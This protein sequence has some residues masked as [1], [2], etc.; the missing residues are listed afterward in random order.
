MRRRARTAS[1]TSGVAALAIGAMTLTSPAEAAPPTPKAAASAPEPGADHWQLSRWHINYDDPESSV[2]TAA[3]RDKNPLEFGYHLQDLLAEGQKAEEKHDDKTALKFWRAVA[4]GVPESNVGF[5]KACRT[6][7]RLGSREKAIE[8][9]AKGLT[10]PPE[11]SPL[12]VTHYA[13]LVLAKD[14]ALDQREIL[15]LDEVSNHLR[16]SKKP[17]ATFYAEQIQCDLAVRLGDEPRWVKCTTALGKL[18]PKDPRTI[19]YQWSLAMKRTDFKAAAG[20][21]AQ[22][23]QSAMKPES[24]A[25]LERALGAARSE[26]RNRWIQIGLG[27]LALALALAFAISRSIRWVRRPRRK[28]FAEPRELPQA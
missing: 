12:E 20:F 22:A 13:S 6:Y 11:Y 28:E 26:Q 21:I 15:D 2:P 5:F 18:A 4:K 14:T 24:L 7:E 16:D 1:R 10:L 3:Q 17:L 19:T 9:C 27:S 25:E 8:F 23:K